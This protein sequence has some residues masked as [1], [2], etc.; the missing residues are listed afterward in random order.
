MAELIYG[1]AEHADRIEGRV[2]LDRPSLCLVDFDEREEHIKPVALLG[3]LRCAPTVLDRC[4]RCAVILVCA[5]GPDVHVVSLELRHLPC[6]DSI[7]F[8]ARPG[9]L[10]EG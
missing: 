5:N 9:E 2:D 1:I 7:I 10:H 4:E 3:T 6:I 8:R